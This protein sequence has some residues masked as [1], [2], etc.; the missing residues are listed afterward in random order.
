MRFRIRKIIITSRAQLPAQATTCAIHLAHVTIAILSQL[1]GSFRIQQQRSHRASRFARARLQRNLTCHST[2]SLA[3]CRHL[4]LALDFKLHW[5]SARILACRCACWTLQFLSDPS[6]SA[7]Q[8][9]RGSHNHSSAGR[10]LN[11]LV[12]RYLES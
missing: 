9:A 3:P 7:A 10:N 1:V 8:P 5:P 12:S 6:D 4:K 11:T 2:F